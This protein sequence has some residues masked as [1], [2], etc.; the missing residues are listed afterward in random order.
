MINYV[1]NGIAVGIC[2]DQ[3]DDEVIW[4][5]TFIACFLSR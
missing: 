3:C 2:G 5:F 4:A 1:K